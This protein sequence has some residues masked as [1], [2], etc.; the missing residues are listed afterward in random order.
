MYKQI[1]F[2]ISET[3]E[4]AREKEKTRQIYENSELEAE[5][6]AKKN[7]RRIHP[8]TTTDPEN[9]FNSM[10]KRVRKNNC[11]PP[12]LAPITPKVHRKLEYSA[13][14][15]SDSPCP[16]TTS[17]IGQILEVPESPLLNVEKTPCVPM[18]PR[19]DLDGALSMLPESPFLH[20]QTQIV[21]PEKKEIT[22]LTEA[23]Q[24]LSDDIKSLKK[25]TTKISKN[26]N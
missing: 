23:V 16:Q 4:A 17:G 22:V 24:R 11:S 14:E 3:Y 6:L 20:T 1:V 8:L 18:T 25:N 15:K 21:R 9:D 2:S 19:E 13:K 10:I 26:L 5:Q 12:P 7:K